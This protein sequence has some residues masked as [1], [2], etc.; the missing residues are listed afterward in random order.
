MFN[1]VTS[2]HESASETLYRDRSRGSDLGPSLGC[3]HPVAKSAKLQLANIRALVIGTRLDVASRSNALIKLDSGG[4][5]GKNPR[6][7]AVEGPVPT[8]DPPADP[9]SGSQWR[10]PAGLPSPD[11]LRGS[12]SGAAR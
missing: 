7:P 2:F 10:V 3:K 9:R 11:Q 8:A 1:S 6:R 4:H 12:E 5:S